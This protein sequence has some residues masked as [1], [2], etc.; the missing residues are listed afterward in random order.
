M[1]KVLEISVPGY[2]ETQRG[3]DV[4]NL[5]D[6]IIFLADDAQLQKIFA[7]N[8]DNIITAQIVGYNSYPNTR[9]NWLSLSRGFLNLLK[10]LFFDSSIY[11][12][13]PKSVYD[14]MRINAGDSNNT[15]ALRLGKNNQGET[16][17]YIAFGSYGD[18]EGG[19]TGGLLHGAVVPPP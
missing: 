16:V 15:L 4:Q 9:V 13:I 7:S 14:T 19:G 5:G 11:L 8:A 2:D 1:A 10:F 3:T 17:I 6:P 12:I 18:A